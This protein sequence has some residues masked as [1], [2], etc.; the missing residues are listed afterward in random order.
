MGESAGAS[1]I[2]HHLTAQGGNISLPFQKAILQSPGFFPQYDPHALNGQYHR[3]LRRA[4]CPLN[5]QSLACLQNL[6]SRELSRANI[7]ETR[8][9]E[10]GQFSWGPAVDGNYVRDLPGRELLKGNFVRNISILQGHNEYVPT[11]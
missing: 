1:S 7:K 4:G 5:I 6:S 2:M 3:F 11:R 10:W 8:L 9:A